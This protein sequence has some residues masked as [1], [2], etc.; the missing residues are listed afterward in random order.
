MRGTCDRRPT[1]RRGSADSVHIDDSGRDHW[2]DELFVERTQ[3]EAGVLPMNVRPSRIGHTR[4]PLPPFYTSGTT[5]AP[6]GDLPRT[7]GY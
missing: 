1:D 2:W 3:P 4:T 6:K 7:G 5:A